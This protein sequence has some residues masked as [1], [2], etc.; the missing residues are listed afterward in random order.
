MKLAFFRAEVA[1]GVTGAWIYQFRSL[2][3]DFFVTED[4]YSRLPET[5]ML[6]ILA[7]NYS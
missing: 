6:L 5:A 7:W 2:Q 1:L 3:L 4:A